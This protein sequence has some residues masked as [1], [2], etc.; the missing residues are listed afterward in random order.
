MTFWCKACYPG[1]ASKNLLGLLIHLLYAHGI[2]CPATLEA[3][4]I[5]ARN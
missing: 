2:Q 3:A 1:Y 4:G 5:Q